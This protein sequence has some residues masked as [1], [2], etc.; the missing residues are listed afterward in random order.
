MIYFL[1]EYLLAH[2]EGSQNFLKPKLTKE[3]IMLSCGLPMMLSIAGFLK[4]MQGITGEI[5]GQQLDE[6]YI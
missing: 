6:K 3:K 5:Y 1:V 2:G 4:I